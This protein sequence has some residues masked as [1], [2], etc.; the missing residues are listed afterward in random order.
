MVSVGP[1]VGAWFLIWL[2]GNVMAHFASAAGQPG[3]EEEESC[4]LAGTCVN[5]RFCARIPAL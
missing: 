2:S 1:Q 5:N 4:L 3:V